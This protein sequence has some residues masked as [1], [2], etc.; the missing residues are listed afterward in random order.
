MFVGGEET[1]VEALSGIKSDSNGIDI[2]YSGV[3]LNGS[4]EPAAKENPFG[5]NI[6][7]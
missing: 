1:Q 7:E 5:D 3:D 4:D 6:F 2:G